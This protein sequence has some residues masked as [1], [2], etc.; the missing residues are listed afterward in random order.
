MRDL[1]WY[2]SL[3]F[4]NCVLYKNMFGVEVKIYI[5]FLW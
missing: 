4:F 3:L 5:K 2:V 1:G